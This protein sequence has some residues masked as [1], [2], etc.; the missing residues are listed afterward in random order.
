MLAERIAEIQSALV[1]AEL[2]GWLF[3]VFQGNDPISLS[4][5][6]LNGRGP[7][8]AP[9][10]LPRAQPG[11]AAPARP[12]PRARHARPPAGTRSRYRTWQ[13][14]RQAMEGLVRD[15]RRLAAQYSPRNELPSVSRLDHGTAS[16]SPRSAASWSPPPTSCSASRR[17][18][19][20]PSSTGTG[21]PTSISIASRAR[22]S[23]SSPATCAPSARSTSGR[24]SASSSRPS[25]APAAHRGRSD[26]G[27]QRPRRR[28]ALRAD[29]RDLAPDPRRRSAADRPVGQGEDAGERLRRHHLC[30]VCAA[31][32]PRASRRS[33]PWC[34]TRATPASSSCAGA[35]RARRSA[36][37]RS[38][39]PCAR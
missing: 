27:R 26:R 23:R 39:T 13:E 34:A 1:E 35:G 16:C 5:L 29:G 11:R 18:G 4:L 12:R 7:G 28:P 36:A 19:R 15:C 21:A 8:H 6:G 30:G 33:G 38:T 10:L 17:S 37:T 14:H 22:P 3:S 9:L 25:R 24:C 20:R 2:D 32:P 31:S